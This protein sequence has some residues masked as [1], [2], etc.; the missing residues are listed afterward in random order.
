MQ[1]SLHVLFALAALAFV[2]TAAVLG[3][4]QRFTIA[5]P[6][7]AFA[8][9]AGQRSCGALPPGAFQQAANTIGR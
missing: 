1:F 8:C 4:E 7:G 3:A 9:H 5:S 6:G 2:S